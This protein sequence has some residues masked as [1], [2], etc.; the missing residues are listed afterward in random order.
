[1]SDSDSILYSD[2]NTLLVLEGQISSTV[3]P[4]IIYRVK[5]EK[6]KVNESYKRDI[7]SQ[8]S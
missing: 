2:S 4:F 8:T 1:M 5:K 6:G 7:H 3:K